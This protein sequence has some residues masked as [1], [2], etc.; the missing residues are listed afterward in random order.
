MEN[1]AEYIDKTLSES[2]DKITNNLELE[3]AWKVMFD[4]IS[5]KDNF[6]DINSKLFV[7]D[8]IKKFYD[9]GKRNDVKTKKK[10]LRRA[11]EKKLRIKSP[12][13]KKEF[14]P[15]DDNGQKTA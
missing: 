7:Y 11:N 9:I 12:K 2:N 8:Q 15:N 3:C 6:N 5:C 1:I 13:N 10:T 4:I 14:P